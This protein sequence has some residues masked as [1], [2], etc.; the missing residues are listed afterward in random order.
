MGSKQYWVVRIIICGPSIGV[1][2]LTAHYRPLEQRWRI[3][4]DKWRQSPVLSSAF[5]DYESSLVA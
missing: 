2:Y 1:G 3:M 4:T 5:L